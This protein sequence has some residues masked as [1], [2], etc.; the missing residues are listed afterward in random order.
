MSYASKILSLT[1]KIDAEDSVGLQLNVGYPD[2]F[3]IDSIMEPIPSQQV[4]TEGQ[5]P[6]QLPDTLQ[7]H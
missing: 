4:H 1:K 7:C 5:K 6:V 3:A 2:D